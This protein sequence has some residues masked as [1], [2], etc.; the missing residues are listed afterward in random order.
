MF[1]VGWMEKRG[2]SRSSLPPSADPFSTRWAKEE[3]GE[4]HAASLPLLCNKTSSPDRLW[5]S[6]IRPWATAREGATKLPK[7]GRNL[8]ASQPEGAAHIGRTRKKS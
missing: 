2:D 7:S 6:D 4:M 8:G 5:F 3:G 1:E